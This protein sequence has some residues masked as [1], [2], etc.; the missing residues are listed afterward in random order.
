M[1]VTK[2]SDKDKV[3]VLDF[4][5]NTFS[6]GDYIAN[7]WDYW[8]AE[9]NLLVIHENNLPVA[10]CHAPIFKEGK[11]VWIEG[12]RVNPNFRRKGCATQ[13]VKEAEKIAKQHSCNTAY[14]LIESNN[15]NS[16]QLARKLNYENFQTWN[17]YSFIPK[18]IDSK[19]NIKFANHEKK[20]PTI[21]FSSN[22]FYVKSW[23]W[24]PLDDSSISVLTN[25]KRIIYFENEDTTNGLAVI[26]DSEHFDKTMITTIYYGSKIGIKEIFSYIQNLANQ[27]NYK[28]IQILTQLK[29]LP[30]YEGLE[31]RLTFF[32]LKKKI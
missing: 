13:L 29:S 23:R 31:N 30:P 26:T 10:I 28:R 17:F 3:K 25:E 7:V 21:L 18:K 1:N 22:L 19:I 6:W 24:L 4:C 15:V 32:L 27:K 5:K 9:G 20:F 11:Q 14:M 2:A 8:L 12:I 16:L